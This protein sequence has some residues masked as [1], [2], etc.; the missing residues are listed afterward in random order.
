MNLNNALSTSASGLLRLPRVLDLT[1]LGKTKLYGLIK[2]GHFPSPIKI[3]TRISAWPE[4]DVIAWI[5]DQ[6]RASRMGGAE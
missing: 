4:S 5:K 3:G 2:E 6:V 1:G